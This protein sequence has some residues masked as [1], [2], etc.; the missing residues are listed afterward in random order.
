MSRISI[1]Q[2]LPLLMAQTWKNP[3][4]FGGTGWL[5]SEQAEYYFRVGPRVIRQGDEAVVCITIANIETPTEY[6]RTG[7]F[8]RTIKRIR[9]ITAW[10]ILLEGAFRDW[11]EHLIRNYGWVPVKQY[12][13]MSWAGEKDL[14]LIGTGERML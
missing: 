2:G 12:Q 9:D 10:P 8:I 14:V 3:S 13:T 11:A 1:E 5:Q 4:L 7:I 6:Q